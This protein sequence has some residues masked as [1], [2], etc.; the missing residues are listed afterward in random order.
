MHSQSCMQFLY[1]YVNALAVEQSLSFQWLFGSNPNIHSCALR[2]TFVNRWTASIASF[3]VHWV[4][5]IWHKFPKCVVE[6]FR[7]TMNTQNNWNQIEQTKPTKSNRPKETAPK[8]RWRYVLCIW[9]ETDEFDNHMAFF[10]GFFH[11]CLL[12]TCVVALNNWLFSFDCFSLAF[13]CFLSFWHHLN[14]QLPF[15][16]ILRP[17]T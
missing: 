17:I 14:I 12:Y 13:S 1:N 4:S 2:C 5:T 10:F 8:C 6:H 9:I 3:Y 11:T 15:V 16:L 7:S